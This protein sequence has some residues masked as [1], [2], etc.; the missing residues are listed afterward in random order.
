MDLGA[1]AAI[2]D[3]REKIS[4]QENKRDEIWEREHKCEYVQLL[5]LQKT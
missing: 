3:L 4:W 2:V 5:G 1:R